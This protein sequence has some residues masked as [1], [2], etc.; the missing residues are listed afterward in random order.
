M[1]LRQG[2]GSLKVSGRKCVYMN[3]GP[4]NI[5][6]VNEFITILED[7]NGGLIIFHSNWYLFFW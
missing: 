5:I 2:V 3:A 7:H 1:A 6:G 4:A